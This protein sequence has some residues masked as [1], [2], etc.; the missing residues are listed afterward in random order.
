MM[1]GGV[2]KQR[3]TPFEMAAAEEPDLSDF[4]AKKDK[5]KKKG[6]KKTED[7]APLAKADDDRVVEKTEA[8]TK[9]KKAKGRIAEYNDDGWNDEM[10]DATKEVDFSGLQ[11]GVMKRED[12][13]EESAAPP[14]ATVS[15]EAE[16]DAEEPAEE[17]EPEVDPVEAMV[18]QSG[19]YRPPGVRNT[20]PSQDWKFKKK[21]TQAPPDMS[22]M[23]F[24]SLAAVADDSKQS[25][26][27]TDGFQRV[28]AGGRVAQSEPRGGGSSNVDASGRYIPPSQRGGG[29]GGGNRY[30]PPG[31]RGSSDPYGGR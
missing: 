27:E 21:S 6:K 29:D 19:V 13:A 4:F 22:E 16:E 28:G 10:P 9:P 5:K 1:I 7:F 15:D 14:A 2:R 20:Q 8:P 31:R 26:R 3:Q 11:I 18:S 30:V 12:E 25:K 23:S 17:P 24:P